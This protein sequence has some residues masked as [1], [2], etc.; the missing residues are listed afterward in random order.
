MYRPV[1]KEEKKEKKIWNFV[2]RLPDS[3]LTAAEKK[4]KKKKELNV[5]RVRSDCINYYRSISLASFSK[6]CGRFKKNENTTY[7]GYRIS[8]GCRFISSRNTTRIHV[9]RRC[10]TNFETD[11]YNSLAEISMIV[12]FRTCKVCVYLLLVRN[13]DA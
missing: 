13:R 3:F 5:I 11:L 10:A 6:T 12:K 8:S 7:I 2:T 1:K 9:P 4:K